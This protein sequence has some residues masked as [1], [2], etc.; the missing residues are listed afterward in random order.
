MHGQTTL[1]LH[2][3]CFHRVCVEPVK[4]FCRNCYICIYLIAWFSD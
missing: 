2:L 3:L 4:V 1:K